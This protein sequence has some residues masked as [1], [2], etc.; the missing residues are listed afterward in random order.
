M[1]I[2]VI[3]IH[4]IILLFILTLTAVM[5][6]HF[7]ELQIGDT[8]N[9]LEEGRDAILAWALARNESYKSAKRTSTSRLVVC[10]N[11]KL[12]NCPFRV[13]INHKQGGECYI[14]K[15]EHHTCPVFSHEDWQPKRSVIVATQD[16]ITRQA[17]Q[18]EEELTA[19][20]ISRDYRLRLG[21]KMTYDH[22]YRVLQATRKALHGSVAES[23]ERIPALLQEMEASEERTTREDGRPACQTR[24]ET[25]MGIFKRCWI[26][27]GATQAASR[28]IRRFLATDGC[29]TKSPSHRMVLLIVSGLDGNDNI[30]PLTWALIPRENENNW[31]WFLSGIQ[32]FLHGIN[33]EESVFISD[34]QKGLR[35]VISHLFPRSRHSNCC[36]HLA[37]NIRARF[38]STKGLVKLFW[39]LA[40]ATTA[41]KYREVLAEAREIDQKAGEY[42]EKLKP[43]SFAFYAFPRSRYGHDTSNIAESINSHW[44]NGRRLPAYRLLVWAWNWMMSKFYERSR[45][46]FKTIRLTDSAIT[47][48]E[49]QRRI[50]VYYTAH[51]STDGLGTVAGPGGNL[52]E[53]NLTRHTCSCGEFQDRQ[54]PCRHA[55]KLGIQEGRD[56]EQLVSR[57]YTIE[58]YRNTYRY[59]FPPLRLSDLQRSPDC[60]APPK[61]RPA[62]RPGVARK[63]SKPDSKAQKCGQCGEVGHNK[64]RCHL[65]FPKDHENQEESSGDEGSPEALFQE[66]NDRYKLRSVAQHARL[67]AELGEEDEEIR[68][69]LAAARN[70]RSEQEQE[71]E[72]ENQAA[73]RNADYAVLR[74]QEQEEQHQ[75]KI[76]REA[77]RAAESDRS[78]I[79][80][81]IIVQSEKLQEQER[82]SLKLSELLEPD[83]DKELPSISDICRREKRKRQQKKQQEPKKKTR[84]NHT[85][86]FRPPPSLPAS[87]SPSVPLI[88]QE[89]LDEWDRESA[90]LEEQLKILEK[91]NKELSRGLRRIN[92][93][94]ARGDNEDEEFAQELLNWVKQPNPELYNLWEDYRSWPVV[95][96]KSETTIHREFL[97]QLGVWATKPDLPTDKIFRWVQLTCKNDILADQV[98]KE[99][100]R[101]FSEG[102]KAEIYDRI[103]T[104]ALKQAI[105]I[106]SAYL[107]LRG[108]RQAYLK[109]LP[110]RRKR[111]AE[112]EKAG[113][114]LTTMERTLLHGLELPDYP[115]GE[116]VAGR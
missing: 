99:E 27:P 45:R 14:S 17:I 112:A 61:I 104:A 109:A 6:S 114:V 50:P 23:F 25:E 93:I 18:E 95:S 98:T 84:P 72:D 10:R 111:L 2:D 1:Y 55:I 32:P 116:A 71:E 85:L 91:R 7:R 88:S 20:D 97:L 46:K 96:T 19:K 36:Q 12:Y 67:E 75:E 57:W 58:E 115:T 15:L 105:E 80:D 52:R 43:Q 47:Y 110:E 28:H 83:T 44:E 100:R 8:F 9:S 53:V 33:S 41:E 11:Q 54:L 102:D 69:I 30:L 37:E 40:R 103:K 87:T 107:E 89:E 64:R 48:L 94:I 101:W 35:N 42:L 92:R 82:E 29:H 68:A 90:A 22:S 16:P 77:D 49:R 62:G 73:E 34:R 5:S 21:R 113:K 59:N 26:F 51:P 60:K 63:R 108:R 39:R 74:S 3:S 81:C 66:E 86:A 4:F 65:H 76:T 56:I 38:G 13:R 106:K 78:S 24:C 79:S 70:A 31:Q